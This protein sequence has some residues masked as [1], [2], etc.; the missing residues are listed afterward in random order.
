MD[1]GAESLGFAMNSAS[2]IKGSLIQ[3]FEGGTI[4][5]EYDG[6]TKITN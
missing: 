2:D 6:K 4:K 1:R 3:K 5:S